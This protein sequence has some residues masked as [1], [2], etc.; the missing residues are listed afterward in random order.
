LSICKDKRLPTVLIYTRYLLQG[1]KRLVFLTDLRKSFATV[2]PHGIQGSVSLKVFLQEADIIGNITV[3][4]IFFGT[5][6]MIVA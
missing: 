3:K 4:S 2:Y 1:E 5:V 6:R